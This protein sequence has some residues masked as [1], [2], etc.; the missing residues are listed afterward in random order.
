MRKRR[1]A[2]PLPRYVI[3]RWSKRTGW[4]HYWNLPGWARKDGCPVANETLGTD[5]EAAV[6]RA[7]AV[8]LPAFDAWRG[9]DA[10]QQEPAHGGPAKAGTLD[11]L[12]AEYRADRRFAKLDPRTRRNHETGFRLVGGYVMNDGHSRDCAPSFDYQRCGR[13]AL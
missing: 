3:R 8:L 11:W 5:Y 1:T 6:K 7:E 4:V 12:F 13:Y 10:P 9:G 2:V